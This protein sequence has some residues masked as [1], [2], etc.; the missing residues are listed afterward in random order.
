[1][2][3]YCVDATSA[4]DSSEDLKSWF[5]L[6]LTT[7]ILG[8]PFVC[9]LTSEIPLSKLKLESLSRLAKESFSLNY[10]ALLLIASGD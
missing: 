1:M 2:C 3:S 7:S 8:E 9:Y 4:F 6:G 5:V 10:A